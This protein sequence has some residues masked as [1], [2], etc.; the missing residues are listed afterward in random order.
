METKYPYECTIKETGETFVPIQIDYDNRNVWHQRSQV[1]C[2]GEWY[3]FD[4]VIFKRIETFID[5]E[6]LEK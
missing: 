4:E 3:S 2:D 6:D 5:L 1:S